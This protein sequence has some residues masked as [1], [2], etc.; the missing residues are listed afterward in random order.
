MRADM[1]VC[2]YWKSSPHLG[3]PPDLIAIQY[4]KNSTMSGYGTFDVKGLTKGGYLVWDHFL[5]VAPRSDGMRAGVRSTYLEG[6]RSK[7]L[8]PIESSAPQS[9]RSVSSFLGVPPISSY[10]GMYAQTL[11]QAT[12]NNTTESYTMCFSDIHLVHH[13]PPDQ[14]P[15]SSLILGFTC[16]PLQPPSLFGFCLPADVDLQ[17]ILRSYPSRTWGLLQHPCSLTVDDAEFS[18]RAMEMSPLPHYLAIHAIVSVENSPQDPKCPWPPSPESRYLSSHLADR[19]ATLTIMSRSTSY[20]QDDS[21]CFMICILKVLRVPPLISNW[22]LPVSG[23]RIHLPL[24]VSNFQ[25]YM[26]KRDRDGDVS[27]AMEGS[28]AYC[29]ILRNELGTFRA[30]I[31]L[32]SYCISVIHGCSAVLSCPLPNSNSNPTP[33]SMPDVET[34]NTTTH[35][36]NLGSSFAYHAAAMTLTL[37]TTSKKEKK[38]GSLGGKVSFFHEQTGSFTVM[39]SND[40][41]HPSIL[42]HEAHTLELPLQPQP[43]LLAGMTWDPSP[44]TYYHHQLVLGS[45]RQRTLVVVSLAIW[46]PI[47]KARVG[48]MQT[49]TTSDSRTPLTREPGPMALAV[50][51]GQD[52]DHDRCPCKATPPVAA[53]MPFPGRCHSVASCWPAAP[54]LLASFGTAL[55]VQGRLDRSWT[56]GKW[57]ALLSIPSDATTWLFFR[58]IP[59]DPGNIQEKERLLLATDDHSLCFQAMGTPIDAKITAK[60]PYGPKSLPETC[61]ACVNGRDRLF[62]S[63]FGGGRLFG[64]FAALFLKYP[65]FV[66]VSRTENCSRVYDSCLTYDD[67][68]FA[69]C[70]MNVDPTRAVN[71]MLVSVDAGVSVHIEWFFGKFS[72]ELR[73]GPLY[74]FEVGLRLLEIAQVLLVAYVCLA[75]LQDHVYKNVEKVAVCMLTAR[76]LLITADSPLDIEKSMT[77]A[78]EQLLHTHLIL[79]TRTRRSMTSTVAHA[80]TE[81]KFNN[82]RYPGF[83]VE[84]SPIPSS[85]TCWPLNLLGELERI[86]AAGSQ[87]SACCRVSS[88]TDPGSSCDMRRIQDAHEAQRGA[89]MGIVICRSP[90]PDRRGGTDVKPLTPPKTRAKPLNAVP[91]NRRFGWYAAVRYQDDADSCM[92][93]FSVSLTILVIQLMQSR[94]E[95]VE[96]SRILRKK[97][98][99]HVVSDKATPPYFPSF[100]VWSTQTDVYPWLGE[101]TGS[102]IRVNSQS[103]YQVV[104]CANRFDNLHRVSVPGF[105][106]MIL[107]R[108]DHVATHGTADPHDSLAGNSGTEPVEVL[109][110]ASRSMVSAFNCPQKRFHDRRP[111]SSRAVETHR[112]PL[113]FTIRPFQVCRTSIDRE[114]NVCPASHGGSAEAFLSLTYGADGRNISRGASTARHLLRSFRGSLPGIAD[115][116]DYMRKAESL[117]SWQL[118]HTGY[119]C[120]TATLATGTTHQRRREVYPSG[121]ARATWPSCRYGLDVLASMPI[122]RLLLIPPE[123]DVGASSTCLLECLANWSM[124]ETGAMTLFPFGLYLYLGGDS[125]TAPQPLSLNVAWMPSSFV[126]E[127]GQRACCMVWPHTP[128]LPADS[129]A[130]A[131]DSNTSNL[132]TKKNSRIAPTALPES[133][134]EGFDNASR[135]VTMTWPSVVALDNLCFDSTPLSGPVQVFNSR[136]PDFG[137]RCVWKLEYLGYRSLGRS[138][139]ETRGRRRDNRREPTWRLLPSFQN[140]QLTLHVQQAAAY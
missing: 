101:L 8:G 21:F 138:R 85:A 135:D 73:E 55:S 117:G 14:A 100:K 39:P 122:G 97:T 5:T 53:R 81:S 33:T 120:V 80:S 75:H 87:F 104:S 130:D 4:P 10:H 12:S 106:T 82:F 126:F 38:S 121:G 74:T 118:P 52:H 107:V 68:I 30:N 113:K 59:V 35:T 88:R 47:R 62:G 46:L 66:E 67:T 71:A 3:N 48:P 11:K 98:T 58:L 139:T 95:R 7:N 17:H 105:N 72:N 92:P 16:L 69:A 133:M 29:H 96:P 115:K 28:K 65:F 77:L 27:I 78:L 103:T 41:L 18:D 43:V 37:S 9:H 34:V 63:T 108:D 49:P 114:K 91:N 23:P 90:R 112:R 26:G 45:A 125:S 76:R 93:A 6:G 19:M 22:C 54:L 89:V 50:F 15:D 137:A 1:A 86:L 128:G 131:V 60:N 79:Y 94:P 140:V 116:N 134:A 2:L 124:G 57:P 64:L 136:V 56:A 31:S 109:R 61:H 123:E 51:A 129:Q 36:S 20:A 13:P 132:P 110:K 119:C 83:P 99:R 102:F 44:A 24:D 127:H 70:T 84:G 111:D 25:F 32:S 42:C 40:L